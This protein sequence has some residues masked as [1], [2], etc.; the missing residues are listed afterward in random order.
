MSLSRHSRTLASTC[1][2][3]LACALPAAARPLGFQVSEGRNLNLF[4]QDGPVAAHL[5][6]R[7]GDDPRL[8][9]AVPAGNSGVGAW[10]KP[11]AKPVRWRAVSP[12]RAVELKDAHGR[13]LRGI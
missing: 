13:T 12:E 7:N 2:L 10:F 3:A 8:L 9:A 11:T 4:R 6:L 5:V 1:V